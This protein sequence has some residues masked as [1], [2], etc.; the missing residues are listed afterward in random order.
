MLK[1]NLS[2]ALDDKERHIISRSPAFFPEQ[3][4]RKSLDEQTPFQE[5]EVIDPVRGDPGG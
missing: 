1:N 5:L 2:R 4:R 3:W